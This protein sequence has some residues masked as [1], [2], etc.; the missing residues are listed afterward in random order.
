MVVTCVKDLGRITGGVTVGRS[1]NVHDIFIPKFC[2]TVQEA[3]IAN[4]MD[5][6]M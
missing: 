4:M 5:L 6:G 3:N 2:A 1:A